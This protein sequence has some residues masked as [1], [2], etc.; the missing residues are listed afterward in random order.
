ML[1]PRE[2]LTDVE[3]SKAVGAHY[4]DLDPFYRSIWGDHVHH[5]YWRTGKESAAEAA[6]ALDLP[7]IKLRGI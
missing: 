1:K 4:D 6:I 7:R 3:M 2:T 5:G